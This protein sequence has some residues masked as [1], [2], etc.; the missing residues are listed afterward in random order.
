MV[1]KIQ[2]RVQVSASPMSISNKFPVAFIGNSCMAEAFHLS[3]TGIVLSIKF[4]FNGKS[5]PIPNEVS[6][7][8]RLRHI[9]SRK[10]VWYGV[11]LASSY[12]TYYA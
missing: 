3:R 6:F 2:G 4:E 10:K 9:T 8:K 7:L 5:L 12:Q 1:Q 11:R